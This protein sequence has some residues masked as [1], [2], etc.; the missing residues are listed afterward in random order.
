MINKTIHLVI[1]LD[2]DGLKDVLGMWVNETE[3]A[4]FW[5]HVLTDLKARGVE[6]ILIASTD[7]LT[8]LTKAI[9]GTFPLTVT[10]LCVVHQIRNSSRYVSWKDKKEFMADLKGIYAAPTLESAEQGLVSFEEKWIEKYAYAI[11]SWKENWSELTQYFDYPVEIRKLIYTT[12]IIENLNRNIRKY[13][14]AKS[15]FPDDNAAKKAVFLAIGNVQK[16]WT[17]PIK[18]WGFIL[19]QF[20]IKFEDRCRL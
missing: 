17:K 2:K 16:K 20:L 8:G 1:G 14:K 10:Q 6:D 15:L 4:S 18:N 5:L 11:K 9:S 19:N 3:S 12:N 13:I 7:N